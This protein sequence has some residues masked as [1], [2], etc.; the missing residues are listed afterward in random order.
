[1]ARLNKEKKAGTAC[2]L[3][4]AAGSAHTTNK[5]ST[6]HCLVPKQTFIGNLWFSSVQAATELALCGHHCIGVVKT[7]HSQFPKNFSRKPCRT[8]PQDHTCSSKQQQE[9]TLTCVRWV[10]VQQQEGGDVSVHK[11]C[12][13]H[14]PGVAC[15]AKWKDEH[16]MNA[17]RHVPCVLD[18]GL[19]SSGSTLRKPT[20]ST[21]DQ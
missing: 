6:V 3:R 21:T 10:Q 20:G 13:A 5:D 14:R 12:W 15:E 2:C 8:G 18:A 1:M 11:G 9:K 17:I 7:A 4:M 19:N 16:G